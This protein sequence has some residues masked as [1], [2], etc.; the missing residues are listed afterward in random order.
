MGLAKYPIVSLH[1]A[2]LKAFECQRIRSQ[3]MDPILE[4]DKQREAAR[5]EV[6]RSTTFKEAAAR[7][8]ET[9]KSK[10]RNEK[11]SKQWVSTLERYAYP[12]LGSLPVQ[13]INQGL[14]MQVL[15]PIWNTKVETASRLRGRIEIVLGWAT[16]LGYRDG[17][18]PARWRGHL[19]LA[20]PAKSRTRRVKHYKSIP[21]KEIASFVEEL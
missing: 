10:W 6:A 3:G 20:L 11:H 8:I 7:Y 19:E 9:N 14:V 2:R 12:V 13:Q 4:R 5:L 15:E 21:H 17:L 16:T 1:E 18:N